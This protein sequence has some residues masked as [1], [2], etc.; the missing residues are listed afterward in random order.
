[1]IHDKK[2]SIG[3]A[4]VLDWAKEIVAGMQYLH[5]KQIIHRDL[6]SPN[7]LLGFDNRLKIS[8]LDSHT[9]SKEVDTTISFRGT[10][11]WM[12]PELIRAEK[13]SSK[14]DVWSFGVVIWE[15]MTRQEPYKN[16]NSNQVIFGVGGGR[17]KLP[18]PSSC[19]S[20]IGGLLEM[21]WNS[22]P[23][24]RPAFFQI[25]N[26]IMV[27]KSEF[28]NLSKFHRFSLEQKWSCATFR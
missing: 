21:C 20:Q 15:L 23:H 22:E 14:V 17:L 26:V 28:E 13:C 16:L 18:I 11:H 1:M 12:A 7:V 4:Q 27:R 24:R 25:K 5:K 9:W 10:P 2:R 8:D 19:P 6:K 3:S